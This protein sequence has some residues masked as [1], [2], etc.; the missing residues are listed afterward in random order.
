MHQCIF[1]KLYKRFV[2]KTSPKVKMCFGFEWKIKRSKV[3]NIRHYETIMC[4]AVR[5]TAIVAINVNNVNVIKQSLSRTIAANFQS[6]TMS[7][8]TSWCFIL[9]V[10]TRSSFKINESSLTA[11]V[12]RGVTFSSRYVGQTEPRSVG[13][14]EIV[15]YDR[16]QHFLLEVLIFSLNMD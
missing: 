15:Q 5:R 4:G 2:L 7:V 11:P 12:G 13:D 3:Y 10:I 1:K 8:A 6:Q 16:D 14:L 9:S